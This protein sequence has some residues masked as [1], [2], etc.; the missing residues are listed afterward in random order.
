VRP[1]R[2]GNLCAAI[3]LSTGLRLG[4]FVHVYRGWKGGG[5][6]RAAPA[7]AWGCLGGAGQQRPCGVAR[8]RMLCSSTFPLSSHLSLWRG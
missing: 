6:L 3:A 5:V 4:I 1:P 2:E 8:G 7:V